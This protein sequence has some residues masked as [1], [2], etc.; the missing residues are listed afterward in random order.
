[1]VGKTIINDQ[2][3]KGWQGVIGY[4]PQECFF[5]PAGYLKT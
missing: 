5:L 4:T 2:T 1:M 3:K